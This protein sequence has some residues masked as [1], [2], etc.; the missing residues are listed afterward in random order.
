MFGLIV[1]LPE[2]G[3]WASFLFWEHSLFKWI[4]KYELMGWS[5]QSKISVLTKFRYISPHHCMVYFCP[6]KSVNSCDCFLCWGNELVTK[7][8]IIILFV[9]QNAEIT[10]FVLIGA[11]SIIQLMKQQL[12]KREWAKDLHETRKIQMRLLLAICYI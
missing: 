9:A 7:T 11:C 5:L 3:D 1:Q 4:L 12:Y 10:K 2:L 6:S 8:K